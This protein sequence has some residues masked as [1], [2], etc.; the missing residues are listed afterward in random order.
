MRLQR[1]LARAGAASRRRSE[2]LMT[3]G[4]V[5]VNGEVV[6]ELGTKVDVRHD[7]VCVDGLLVKLGGRPVFLVLNKPTGCLTTMDDPQGRPT[8]RELVPCA[9]HPGLFAVGRLDCDTTGLLLFTT[10]GELAHRLLH[11]TR[12]VPKRYVALVDG[13]LEEKDAQALRT[14][15]LLDDG[16]TRP[17]AVELL[18]RSRHATAAHGAAAVSGQDATLVALTLTEG[19]KRQVKRMCAA[20]GHPVLAL[21]RERFGPLELRGVAP[22]A[23]RYLDDDEV[24][25]LYAAVPSV[26]Q[27]ARCATGEQ[28]VS[29]L[30]HL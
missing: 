2:D 27:G 17:A 5:T 18:D 15:V 10:D 9:A 30:E 16:M 1:Y 21:H 8:V 28:G 11:P 14:G 24:A 6:T 4:R 22:G 13:L 12:H 29:S 7:E 25:A 23:W 26:A 19:R 20:V 3:A